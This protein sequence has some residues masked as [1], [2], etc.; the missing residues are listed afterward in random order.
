MVSKQKLFEKYKDSIAAQ[1]PVAVELDEMELFRTFKK[2]DRNMNGILEFSEYTQCL[3]EC[4]GLELTKQE[5]ITSALAAD[6]SGDG[7]IDFEEFMKH[8]KDI[9]NMQHMNQQLQDKLDE[10][11]ARSQREQNA[12]A[13]LANLNTDGKDAKASA[14]P[15]GSAFQ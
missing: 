12:A 7:K 3:S 1:H 10:E 4:P 9:I 5:I 13:V 14:G 8:F 2:Y 15:S 6:I 11:H